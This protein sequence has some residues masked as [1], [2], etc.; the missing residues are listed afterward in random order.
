[1]KAGNPQ[2]RPLQECR[3]AEVVT[4]ARIVAMEMECARMCPLVG[5]KEKKKSPEMHFQG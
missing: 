2:E 5:D 4:G 1:M 3:P